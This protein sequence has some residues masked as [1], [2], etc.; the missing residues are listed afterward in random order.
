MGCI[1]PQAGRQNGNPGFRLFIVI[2][3]VRKRLGWVCGTLSLVLTSAGCGCDVVR[4]REN[5]TVR[6]IEDTDEVRRLIAAQQAQEDATS[7]FLRERLST[8]EW[9]RRTKELNEHPERYLP[10]RK[11]FLAAM[12]R[13]PLV[14]VSDDAHGSILDQSRAMCALDSWNTD[15][16]IKIR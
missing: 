2:G 16:Y 14:A 11:E 4:I 5:V 12:S 1:M 3:A 7:A 15:I 6:L 8:E 13:R 9:D 10:V